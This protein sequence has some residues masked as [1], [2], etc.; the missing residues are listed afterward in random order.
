MT[1]WRW[2]GKNSVESVHTSQSLLLILTHWPPSSSAKSGGYNLQ[3][4]FGLESICHGSKNSMVKVSWQFV[5]P[6]SLQHILNM[7]FIASLYEQLNLQI[8]YCL[9][10]EIASHH[11]W[12]ELRGNMTCK[13]T[14]E[15]EKN[16][17]EMNTERAWWTTECVL[18]KWGCEKVMFRKVFYYFFFLLF[19]KHST[20]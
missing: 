14:R 16:S 20:V 8:F 19:K 17:I 15:H 13:L 11:C 3:W 9:E 1:T 12:Q 2:W 10:N 6:L 7:Y 4:T 5:Q 18:S